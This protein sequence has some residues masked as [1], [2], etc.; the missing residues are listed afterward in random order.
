MCLCEGF[1]FFFNLKKTCFEE[2]ILL[3]FLLYK[4]NKYL[5]ETFSTYFR[6]FILI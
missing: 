2:L 6:E 4:L 1:I 3:S 5:K